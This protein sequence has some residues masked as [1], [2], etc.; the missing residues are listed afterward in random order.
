MNI[1][2]RLRGA[3]R[4]LTADN[5]RWAAWGLVL[6]FVILTLVAGFFMG[7]VLGASVA[8]DGGSISETTA[9]VGGTELEIWE[10]QMEDS[11][12]ERV[13]YGLFHWYVVLVQLVAIG[14]LKLG[15]VVPT[16][17]Y[18]MEYSGIVIYSLIGLAALQITRLIEFAYFGKEAKRE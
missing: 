13:V 14:G 15:Y 18:L 16:L 10:N 8:V 11:R 9:D 6:I 7:V 2:A 1:K 3:Y 12:L 4:R 5:L 17:G